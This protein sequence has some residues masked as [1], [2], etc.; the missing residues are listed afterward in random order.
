M[1]GNLLS[2]T[3]TLRQ[4]VAF[5]QSQIVAK[6]TSPNYARVSDQ[7]ILSGR[8]SFSQKNEGSLDIPIVSLTGILRDLLRF[9][10][11]SG[12]VLLQISFKNK[13]S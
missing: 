5:D 9:L 2:L 8:G 13:I 4:C 12:T 10:L 7:S 3:T 1:A 6:M 11:L